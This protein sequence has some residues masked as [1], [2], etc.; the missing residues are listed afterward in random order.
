[1]NKKALQ[2]VGVAALAP[3]SDADIKRDPAAA[4]KTA[5]DAMRAALAGFAGRKQGE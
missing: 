3:W 2:K 1:V 4:M 5:Q